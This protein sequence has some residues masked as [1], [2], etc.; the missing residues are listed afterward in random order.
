MNFHSISRDHLV[1]ISFRSTTELDH[2]TTNRRH[3]PRP[4]FI[5]FSEEYGLTVS[6]LRVS[7]ET[8]VVPRPSFETRNACKCRGIVST[9]CPRDARGTRAPFVF[10]MQDRV[11]CDPADR[12]HRMVYAAVAARGWVRTRFPSASVIRRQTRGERVRVRFH[13]VTRKRKAVCV[14]VNR[15]R[16]T[17][18]ARRGTRFGKSRTAHPS[19]E[20]RVP[21]YL[22]TRPFSR[23]VTRFTLESRKI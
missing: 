23:L 12:S 13:V 1:V 18:G 6:I 9:G 7:T 4:V 8:T 10:K 17:R 2:P 11:D 19:S 5:S 3:R 15:T 16:Y 21:A 20:T 14:S 22:A